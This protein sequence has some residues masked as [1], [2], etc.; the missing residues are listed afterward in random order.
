MMN[1]TRNKGAEQ[2]MGEALCAHRG[3]Q[4]CCLTRGMRNAAIRMPHP[5][6]HALW[7]KEEFHRSHGCAHRGFSFAAH[8]T[9]PQLQ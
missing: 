8:T 9:W 6:L 2:R 3:K 5:A 1:N 7:K 4:A